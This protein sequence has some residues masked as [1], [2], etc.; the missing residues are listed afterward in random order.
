[1]RPQDI[2]L[3]LGLPDSCRVDQRVPKKVLIENGAPTSADKR[4]INEGIKKSS[5]LRRS[6]PTPSALQ[7]IETTS[8]ST[9]RSQ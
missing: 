2:I 9:W 8:A 4:S 1:M 7:R 5:G 3:A 6:S